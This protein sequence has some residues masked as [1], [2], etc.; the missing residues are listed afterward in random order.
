MLNAAPIAYNDS[1]SIHQ[2]QTLNVASNV[3]VLSN[4][5]DAD[6]DTLTASVVS[7]PLHGAMLPNSDGSFSYTPFSGYAGADSFTYKANDGT[8]DSNNATVSITVTNTARRPATTAP[9]MS[10]RARC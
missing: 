10:T 4:D 7:S 8:V 2:G 5:T 6:N 3:G 9:I 1:H